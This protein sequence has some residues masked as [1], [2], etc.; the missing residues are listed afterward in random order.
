MNGKQKI[1]IGKSFWWWSWAIFSKAIFTRGMFWLGWE[2]SKQIQNKSK[3]YLSWKTCFNIKITKIAWFICSR[4]KLQH[5]VMP[6]IKTRH[7]TTNIKTGG[8]SR[9]KQVKKRKTGPS[10]A[11][12]KFYYDESFGQFF[13]RGWLGL[14]Q[15]ADFLQIRPKR[16]HMRKN[17]M[18]RV[19]MGCNNFWSGRQTFC[20][21]GPSKRMCAKMVKRVTVACNCFW[22]KGHSITRLQ[23]FCLLNPQMNVCEPNP[24]TTHS[25]LEWPMTF[26]NSKMIKFQIFNFFLL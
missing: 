21:F 16:A 2:N 7:I 9:V 24:N 14:C 6:D 11:A 1:I 18:K 20:K 17:G 23:I 8:K 25:D 13:R 5:I 10:Q 26:V 3:D 12:D 15:Q 22:S 19:I 4:R